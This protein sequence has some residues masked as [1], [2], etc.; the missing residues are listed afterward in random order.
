MQARRRTDCLKYTQAEKKLYSIITVDI[1][2]ALS[3][4][5]LRTK[6][7]E[8]GE[9]ATVTNDDLDGSPRTQLATGAVLRTRL[10]TAFAAL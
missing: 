4:P 3:L 7:K 2:D 5:E 8:I 9:R 6:L 1:V 10:R